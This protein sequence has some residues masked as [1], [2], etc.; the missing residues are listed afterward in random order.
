MLGEKHHVFQGPLEMPTLIVKNRPFRLMSPL[1]I[2]DP[3]R[4]RRAQHSCIFCGIRL[5]I[6]EFFVCSIVR[7]HKIYGDARVRGFF[8]TPLEWNL[9][10]IPSTFSLSLATHTSFLRSF[11]RFFY[12]LSHSP[13]ACLETRLNS[14]VIEIIYLFGIQTICHWMRTQRRRSENI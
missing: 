11:S 7:W 13:C 8:Q 14:I 10:E 6:W 3:F 4:K 9:Y 5:S 2:R 1:W 12:S